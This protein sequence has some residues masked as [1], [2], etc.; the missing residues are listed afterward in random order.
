MSAPA[1]LSPGQ[2]NIRLLIDNLRA[3]ERPVTLPRIN[4]FRGAQRHEIEQAAH[5]VERQFVQ[6]VAATRALLDHLNENLPVGTKVDA[7]SFLT[8]VVDGAADL[9]LDIR[10]MADRLEDAR[11]YDR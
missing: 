8:D 10:G 4:A 9:V 3:C 7:A 1:A 11:E 2:R 5:E 6:C